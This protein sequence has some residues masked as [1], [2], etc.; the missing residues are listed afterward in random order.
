VYD[1]TSDSTRLSSQGG[2]YHV[3]D[4]KGVVGDDNKG[5][6]NLLSAGNQ[7]EQ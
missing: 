4:P 3:K 1:R 7:S 5:R 2:K 6:C